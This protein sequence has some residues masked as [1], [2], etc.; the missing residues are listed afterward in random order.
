MRLDTHAYL[1]HADLCRFYTFKRQYD[2]AVTEC[3]RAIEL[4]PS[5]AVSYFWLAE[6][7]VR[8]GKPNEAIGLVEKTERLDPL[9]R[10]A[11]E[12]GRGETFVIMGDMQR[13]FP[14]SRRTS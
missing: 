10:V 3:Q 12:G 7:S 9:H 1:A 14:S 2:Q 6:A 8:S 5:Y 13:R 11:W 4:A